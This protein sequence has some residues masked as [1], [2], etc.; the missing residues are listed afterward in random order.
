ME[1]YALNHLSVLPEN[2]K[3]NLSRSVFFVE[4]ADDADGEL[5]S[6]VC[7]NGAG[8]NCSTAVQREGN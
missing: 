1:I 6:A 5:L 7:H 2:L 8:E 3:N 4:G